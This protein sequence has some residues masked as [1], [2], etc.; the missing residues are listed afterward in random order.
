MRY[1]SVADAGYEIFHDLLNDYYR[2]GE[3]AA[4]PQEEIDEFIQYLFDMCR[5]GCISGC[6][7]YDPL[8]VG[9]VLWNID[10]AGGVFSRKPGLGT[11][12]EIGVT[13][14]N[15]G[16]GTGR[17]LVSYAESRMGAQSC[18]VCAYGPAET[19]WGKCGYVFAGER[20]ENGLKIMVKGDENGR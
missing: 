4:T 17:K 1:I 2:D 19:F 6:I 7:A 13:K 10:S 3:D 16:M 12:L 15:R 8:P 20:A 18:Y 11:I 9:F 14:T 5:T